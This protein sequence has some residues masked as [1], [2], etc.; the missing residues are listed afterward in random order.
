MRKI[1]VMMSMVKGRSMEMKENKK[2]IE[3]IY[4]YV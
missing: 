3:N 1:R 2:I 4:I